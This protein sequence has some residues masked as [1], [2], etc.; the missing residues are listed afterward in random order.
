[1][2]VSVETLVL[3]KVAV[4]CTGTLNVLTNLAAAEDESELDSNELPVKPKLAKRTQETFQ[5]RRTNNS[6]T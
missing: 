6:P 2:Y 1:M 5:I 3:L 4:T